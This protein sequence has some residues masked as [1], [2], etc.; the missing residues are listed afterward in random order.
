VQEDGN[1]WIGAAV[2]LSD[3]QLEEYDIDEY[4]Q[5]VGAIRK[6]QT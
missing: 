5:Q 4:V 2:N 3:E 6:C 1:Q